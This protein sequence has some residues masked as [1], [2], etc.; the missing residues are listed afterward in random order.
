MEN[1]DLKKYNLNYE[2][3][4]VQFMVELLEPYLQF[5]WNEL[6]GDRNQSHRS[7]GPYILDKDPTS[8]EVVK[9]LKVFL[10]KEGGIKEPINEYG[11]LHFIQIDFPIIIEERRK[12]LN[13]ELTKEK[14]ARMNFDMRVNKVNG[15]RCP[16]DMGR[17][18]FD[19]KMK[20]YEE[21]TDHKGKTYRPNPT[22]NM[23][24]PLFTRY[25]LKVGSLKSNIKKIDEINKIYYN[26]NSTIKNVFRLL[27]DI[28]QNYTKL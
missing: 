16:S 15:F 28:R 3:Q 21:I 9:T 22:Q 23:N 20:Y 6:K 17:H 8:T 10:K 1:I 11:F 19:E 13:D 24:E 12:M 5:E 18:E 4:F 26:K 25:S 7:G 2:L 14:Q 27:K